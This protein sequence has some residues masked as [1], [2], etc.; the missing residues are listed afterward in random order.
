[1]ILN[2]SIQIWIWDYVTQ[3]EWL[4]SMIPNSIEDEF[5]WYPTVGI[6]ILS[7][8]WVFVMIPDIIKNFNSVN[9]FNW[10]LK[11]EYS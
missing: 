9:N 8:I 10:Y 6:K 11:I 3:E 5:A 4:N 7:V 2:E 1:M